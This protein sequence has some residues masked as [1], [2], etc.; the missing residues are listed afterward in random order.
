MAGLASS[1]TSRVNSRRKGAAGEREL[2]RLLK[3]HGFDARRGQQYSG[4][5]GDDVVGLPGIHVECKRAERLNV[6]LAMAQAERDAKEGELPAV[7]HRKNRREWLVTM[8]L[9]DWI[10][11]YRRDSDV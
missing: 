10:S 9:E 4:L 2:A 5:G 3:E 11:I 6:D 1:S 7:F 8:R